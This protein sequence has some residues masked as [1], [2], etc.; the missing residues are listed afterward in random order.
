M[1]ETGRRLAHRGGP[2]GEAPKVILIGGTSHAG[3]S[4]LARAL[5]GRLGYEALSTD[6]LARHPG[7]PWRHGDA[8]PPHVVEHYSTLAPEALIAS[9][10]QHYEGMWPMVRELVVR[11]AADTQATGTQATGLVLEGSA[12]LPDRVA[13][14]GREDVAAF[15]LTA[16]EALLAARMRTE[17]RYDEADANGRALIDAFLERTRRYQRLTNEAVLR[18]GLPQLEV[19]PGEPIEAIADRALALMKCERG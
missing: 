1:S 13:E 5:A 7:R 3:K 6:Q 15:W 2:C 17:S 16:D 14:L 19:H 4:S 8:V 18:L 11:R 10:M 9:V 12:L